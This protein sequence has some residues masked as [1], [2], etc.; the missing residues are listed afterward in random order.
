[1]VGKL[2]HPAHVLKV[3]HGTPDVRGRC[4]T[5]D[6]GGH[7]GRGEGQIRREASGAPSGKVSSGSWF[8]GKK[9]PARPCKYLGTEY[10]GGTLPEKK[11]QSRNKGTGL[12]QNKNGRPS[13]HRPVPAL[14]LGISRL[15]V[16]TCV[17]TTP[18]SGG[19]KGRNELPIMEASRTP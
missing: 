1:M 12:T 13:S 8:D 3:S 5:S 11:P 16:L 7:H 4:G 19:S 10:P 2:T 14:C 15:G 9:G 17:L 6:G 18:L